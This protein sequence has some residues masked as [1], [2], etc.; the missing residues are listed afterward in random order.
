M[1]DPCDAAIL[2]VSATNGVTALGVP[3]AFSFEFAVE[4]LVIRGEGKLGPSCRG[5]VGYDFVAVVDFLVAPPLNPIT[6]VPAALVIVA[7]DSD[8]DNITDTLAN[9]KVLGYAKQMD[10]DLE[11]DHSRL[12][13]WS[14]RRYHRRRPTTATRCT[15]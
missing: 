7:K 1:A 15:T 12:G 2:L 6:V 10:R 9:M 3:V 4:E 13:A 5:D 11:P 8:G 14:K